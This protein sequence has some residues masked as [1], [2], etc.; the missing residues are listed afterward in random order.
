MFEKAFSPSYALWKMLVGQIDFVFLSLQILPML[1]SSCLGIECQVMCQVKLCKLSELSGM[2]AGL[3][4]PEQDTEFWP[5]DVSTFGVHLQPSQVLD[6]DT[7]FPL[8]GLLGTLKCH[9]CPHS[10]GDAECL[11]KIFSNIGALRA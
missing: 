7:F 4:C 9:K 2:S 1:V 10:V 3:G 8:L 11:H 5:P 6:S